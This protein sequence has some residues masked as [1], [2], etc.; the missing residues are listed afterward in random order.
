MSKHSR[1]RRRVVLVISGL[2]FVSGA[3]AFAQRPA[4]FTRLFMD[5]ARAAL[6]AVRSSDPQSPNNRPVVKLFLSGAIERDNKQIPVENAG[7]VKPGEVVTFTMAS[8]NAGSAPARQYRA[9]GLIPA[10]TIFVANSAVGD[11]G[12]QVSYSIDDGKEFS[13]A[14]M[15]D[16]KQPDGSVK[17]VAAPLSMYTQVR[18][19]W[20]DP[21]VPGGKVVA[22]YQVRVK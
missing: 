14:P 10:G 12:T 2:L 7:P 9:V 21:L 20:A 8:V 17:K 13:S 5:P 6:A 1:V 4:K 16:E 22:A 15:I 11:S 19:E 3:V 18:F